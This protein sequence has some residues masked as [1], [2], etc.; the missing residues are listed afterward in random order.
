MM[1]AARQ[2]LCLCGVMAGLT[3]PDVT[4]LAELGWSATKLATLRG[5]REQVLLE[6]LNSARRKR[7][8]FQADERVMGEMIEQ[9]DKRSQNIHR[10]DAGRGSHDLLEAHLQHQREKRRRAFSDLE[11][12]ELVEKVVMV[13]TAKRVK[14]PTRLGRKLHM[15]GSDLALREQAEKAERDRWLGELRII[16]RDAKLP[17]ALR[18]SEESLMLRIAKG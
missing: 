17:V 2:E 10:A 3:D 7:E 13:G 18:S 15:A 6:V 12:A 1:D 5:C 14:W 4:T 8:S 9:C 16:M 11:E